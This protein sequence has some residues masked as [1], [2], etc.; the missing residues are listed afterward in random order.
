M[1]KGYEDTAKFGQII[2][3]S[4]MKSLEGVQ[5]G[6]QAIAVEA[7]DYSRKAFE[8]GAASFEKLFAAKSPEK[9]MEIRSAFM[10]Q[11]YDSFVAQSSRMSE[12]LTEVAREAYKPF[13]TAV[14]KVE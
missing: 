10:R 8:A 12:L 9:A 4:G 6:M 11:A 13:E 2:V 1:F 14:S 7:T 5:N 3:D